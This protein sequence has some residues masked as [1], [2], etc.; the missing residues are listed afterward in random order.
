MLREWRKCALVIVV[1]SC[2]LPAWY[3]KLC[4]VKSNEN[5]GKEKGKR[6]K[7]IRGQRRHIAF[8]DVG[9][10]ISICED[11]ETLQLYFTFF[12]FLPF[13]SSFAE[14]TSTFPLL[15]D[16]FSFFLLGHRAHCSQLS[17]AKIDVMCDM[18]DEFFFLFVSFF[19]I[20]NSFSTFHNL[21][22]CLCSTHHTSPTHSPAGDVLTFF[23]RWKGEKKDGQQRE[24]KTFWAA[25]SSVESLTNRL[26][27]FTASPSTTIFILHIIKRRDDARVDTYYIHLMSTERL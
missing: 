26:Y 7:Y 21:M 11:A 10:K 1:G 5:G 24:F 27:M 15:I 13:S 18:R 2:V 9:R 14:N 6:K 17:R 3:E 12:L 22:R 4:R 8:I 23:W 16:S 19:F 20:K 25:P